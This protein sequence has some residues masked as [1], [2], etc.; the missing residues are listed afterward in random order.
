V[1]LR[2]PSTDFVLGAGSD[3]DPEAIAARMASGE[4]GIAVVEDRWHVDLMGALQQRGGRLPARA[5]CVEAFNVMRGCPLVFSIYVTGAPK[6]D[7][8]CNVPEHYSCRG[9]P[10]AA[11]AASRC[12]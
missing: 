7:P 9:A 2:E 6:L 5:G 3:T 8:G 1:G 10:P 4:E 11:A 12:R